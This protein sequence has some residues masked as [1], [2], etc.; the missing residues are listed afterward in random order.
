MQNTQQKV[1]RIIKDL[2]VCKNSKICL[3][4]NTS[5]GK[6]TWSSLEF[7]LLLVENYDYHFF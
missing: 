7:V 2:K 1:N 5:F 3:G 4:I 6:N